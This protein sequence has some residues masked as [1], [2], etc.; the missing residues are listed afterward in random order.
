[1]PAFSGDRNV[2]CRLRWDP[3]L[4]SAWN[5]TLFAAR[6]SM[7]GPPGGDS[8]AALARSP[9]GLRSQIAT[10]DSINKANRGGGPRGRNDEGGT[11]PAGPAAGPRDNA[12]SPAPLAC[13]APSHLAAR[14]FSRVPSPHGEAGVPL[15]P[16]ARAFP[17]SHAVTGA[18]FQRPS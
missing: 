17:S 9:R 7:P 1:M 6:L 12:V 5:A 18:T 13:R 11:L 16:F 10:A 14:N 2:R 15:T 4:L 3:Q 8:I